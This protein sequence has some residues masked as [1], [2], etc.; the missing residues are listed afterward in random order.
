MLFIHQF[1]TNQK[2]TP[3]SAVIKDFGVKEAHKGK[4]T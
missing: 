4:I 3:Q 2:R 1:K